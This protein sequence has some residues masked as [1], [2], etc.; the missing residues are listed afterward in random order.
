MPDPRPQ[1]KT[2]EERMRKQLRVYQHFAA[3]AASASRSMADAERCRLPG[4]GG[5]WSRFAAVQQDA[6]ARSRDCRKRY[7]KLK[8]F[9][10]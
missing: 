2:R 8:A 1:P 9:D 6:A 10:V 4:W 7:A 5:Y 3:I